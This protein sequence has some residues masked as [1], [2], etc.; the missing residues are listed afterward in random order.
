MQDNIY[1]IRLIFLF[2]VFALYLYDFYKEIVFYT[3]MRT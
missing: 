1:N 3:N 2:R